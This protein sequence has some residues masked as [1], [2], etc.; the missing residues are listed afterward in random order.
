MLGMTTTLL[1]R[2]TAMTTYTCRWKPG[3]AQAPDH[4]ASTPLGFRTREPGQRGHQAS[5]LILSLFSALDLSVA[6]LCCGRTKEGWRQRR[7][8]KQSF[9]STPA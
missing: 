3:L 5:Y 2:N 4:T 9:F 8:S 6:S 7:S 1:F